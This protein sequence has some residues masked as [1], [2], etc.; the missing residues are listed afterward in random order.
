MFTSMVVADYHLHMVTLV[1]VSHSG[2]TSSRDQDG[3]LGKAAGRLTKG[4]ECS[5][6]SIVTFQ[7]IH[8]YR[9]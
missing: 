5:W 8:T 4:T 2:Q 1:R 3:E 9:T 7:I 6:I